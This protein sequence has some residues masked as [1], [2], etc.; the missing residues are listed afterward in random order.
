MR[1]SK[2]EVRAPIVF[3]SALAAGVN[4]FALTLQQVVIAP[5]VTTC[6]THIHI[7]HEV[8]TPT[9]ATKKTQ[10]Y[11]NIPKFKISKQLKT[12]T[13]TH[14]P[15]FDDSTSEAF[16]DYVI[17]TWCCI[18][19]QQGRQNGQ[20]SR[21]QRGCALRVRVFICAFILRNYSFFKPPP[22]MMS[23]SSTFF[24][25]RYNVLRQ[26][27]GIITYEYERY[28]MSMKCRNQYIHFGVRFRDSSYDIL[29]IHTFVVQTWK[30]L[31]P[32][33][34]TG[35]AKKLLQTY[36]NNM[37]SF[38]E[39]HRTI[40]PGESIELL[41]SKTSRKF[42]DEEQQNWFYEL[43]MPTSMFFACITYFLSGKHRNLIDRAH[44]ATAFSALCTTICSHSNGL[45][46]EHTQLGSGQT[47]MLDV[48]HAGSI[49]DS[50]TFWTEMFFVGTVRRTWNQDF[51]SSGKSW[52]QNASGLGKNLLSDLICFCLD[53]QHS[54]TLRTLYENR[55]CC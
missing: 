27:N 34:R 18:H 28:R 43:T 32:F 14:C 11:V 38:Q 1:S 6:C 29:Q 4:H 16:S 33:L 12:I 7:I 46:L 55:C 50:K 20:S 3:F 19:H 17:R 53:P 26:W 22:M 8:I 37:A 39:I 49:V 41:A 45:S 36:N 30:A 10:V 2:Q 42:R 51:D 25:C 48:D 5:S 23:F 54:S 44:A 13:S 52:V 24:L 35:Q 31:Q 47:I 15:T 40:W 21:L 9:V